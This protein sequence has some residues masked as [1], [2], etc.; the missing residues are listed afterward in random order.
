[1]EKIFGDRFIG[2]V[3]KISGSST[4]LSS[5]LTEPLVQ[6]FDRHKISAGSSGNI[7]LY[8]GIHEV[9]YVSTNN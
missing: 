8:L 7:I 5:T 2:H 4:S 1:L 9:E 3:L 6:H